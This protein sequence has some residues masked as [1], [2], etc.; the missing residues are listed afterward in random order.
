MAGWSAIELAKN[1]SLV[2]YDSSA[3]NGGSAECDGLRQNISDDLAEYTGSGEY[4]SSWQ[5]MMARSK[6]RIY[7]GHSG[8]HR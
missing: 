3:K 7:V 8:G 5:N 4:D 1:D 6:S 2:E